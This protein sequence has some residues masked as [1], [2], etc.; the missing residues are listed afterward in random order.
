MSRRLR[1]QSLPEQGANI[2]VLKDIGIRPGLGSDWSLKSAQVLL[3]LFEG[4]L[5][6]GVKHCDRLGPNN[7]TET[8]FVGR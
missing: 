7:P 2:L 5:P 6:L 3:W 8:R 1:L 4:N